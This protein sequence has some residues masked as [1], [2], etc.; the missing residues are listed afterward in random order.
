MPKPSRGEDAVTRSRPFEPY[1]LP[2]SAASR[3]LADTCCA[4]VEAEEVKHRL[5]KRTRRAADRE[6]FRALVGALVSDLAYRALET[7]DDETGINLTL[8]RDVLCRRSERYT[9]PWLGKTL[10]AVLAV[11]AR[12][13]VALCRVTKG[14][15]GRSDGTPGTLTEVFPGPALLDRL[16]GLRLSDFDLCETQELVMLRDGRDDDGNR[17]ALV[18]Y[19]DDETTERLRAEVRAI[20]AWLAEADI[21]I[22]PA[23]PGADRIDTSYRRLR[24]R[25]TNASFTSG[26]RLFGGFWQPMKK[27]WRRAI[28]INGEPVVGLDYNGAS[29]RMLYGKAGAAMP[30]E[31]PYE[32]GPLAQWPRDAIKKLFASMTFDST[33]KKNPKATSG[34]RQWPEDV[35]KLFILPGSAGANP[36]PL[37]TVRTAIEQAHKPIR[38]LLY[39]GIGHELQFV[40]SGLMVDLLLT[41]KGMGIVALPI[42]D[43]LI[44]QDS[45]SHRVEGLMLHKFILHTGV[46]GQV[47]VE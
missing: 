28:R 30:D 29:L 41:L 46:E 17:G 24:R 22:D 14:A 45:Q 15:R 26:G 13:D 11:M 35:R 21:S 42:H 37:R 1:R 33:L 32:L 2:I 23:A 31:D 25:F 5:R 47:K 3:A 9:P 19:R 4:L 34:L 7:G 20:N 38:H 44:V 43:C 40:E 6:T 39:R 8:S 16:A 12:P 10:P 36:P 18:D 27:A